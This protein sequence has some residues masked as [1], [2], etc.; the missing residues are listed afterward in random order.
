MFDV[1]TTHILKR[2]EAFP[3]ATFRESELVDISKKAFTQLVKEGYL[4][5]DHYDED[6]DSYF[7]DRIGDG[8]VQ[9]TIRTRNNKVTA[10]SVEEGVSTI[11]LAKSEITYH[12]F[13]LNKLVDQIRTQN[14]LEEKIDDVDDRLHFIGSKEEG[15]GRVGIYFALYDSPKDLETALFALPNTANRYVQYF[16]ISPAQQITSQKAAGALGRIGVRHGLLGA[17]IN[18][19]FQLKADVFAVKAGSGVAS[20]IHFPGKVI[21]KKCI[22]KIGSQEAGLTEGNY[23]LLLQMALSRIAKKDGWLETIKMVQEGHATNMMYTGQAIQRLS[24]DL[25]RSFTG[26]S[27]DSFIESG[28]KKYRLAI[29]KD[30]ISFDIGMLQKMKVDSALSKIIKKITTTLKSGKSKK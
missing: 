9:R 22:V 18:G 26:I 7:S 12:R 23:K 28:G 30:K 8:D 14:Q 15:G 10:F 29:P 2:L 21:K 3:D 11:E 24:D 6:G 17:L 1:L 13:S 19:K 16:V 5:F 25:K 4:E 20:N 27:F